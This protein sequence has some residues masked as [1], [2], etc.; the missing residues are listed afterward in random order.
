MLTPS[1]K[2]VLALDDYLTEV[3]PDAYVNPPVVCY[4]CIS[5]SQT[6]LQRD[7]ALHRIHDARKFGEQAVAR[8]FEDPAVVLLNFRF[9]QLFAM[10]PQPVECSGL[11]LLH[12]RGIPHHIRREDRGKPPFHASFSGG[13]ATLLW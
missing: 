3:D 7:R 11:V 8:E 1:A 10:S 5:L 2:A 4:V 6:T 9:E 13:D 12:E